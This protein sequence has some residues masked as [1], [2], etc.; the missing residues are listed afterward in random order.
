[1]NNNA[2]FAVE[3]DAFKTEADA[4]E[5]IEENWLKLAET[6]LDEDQIKK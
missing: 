4:E 3:K 1:M 5:G 2:L 6:L